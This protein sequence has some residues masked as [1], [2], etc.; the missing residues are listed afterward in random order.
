MEGS[1]EILSIVEVLPVSEIRRRWPDA[2]KARIVAEMLEA[3]A[4]VAGVARRHDVK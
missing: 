3:G 2:L 4:T 1:T